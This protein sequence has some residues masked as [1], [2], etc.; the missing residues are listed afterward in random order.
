[1]YSIAARVLLSIFYTHFIRFSDVKGLKPVTERQG[2]TW[3]GGPTLEKRQP[4]T[5][6]LT[7]LIILAAPTCLFL[8][9]GK[10]WTQRVF[11]I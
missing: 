11:L 3:T 4:C 9:Y 6:T 7:P 10:T 8:D 2:T 1:M 5:L